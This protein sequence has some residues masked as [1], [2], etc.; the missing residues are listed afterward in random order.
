MTK[1]IALILIALT[2]TFSGCSQKEKVITKIEYIKQEKYDFNK[3]NLDGAYI[4]LKDKNTQ[5]VCSNSLNELNSFYKEVIA[6]YD[7]QIDN[8]KEENNES[9]K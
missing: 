4:V 6:F 1:T 9:T 5:K 3:I 2:F 8:Y 7:W